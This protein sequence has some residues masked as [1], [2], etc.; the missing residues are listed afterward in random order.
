MTSLIS[1]EFLVAILF[2]ANGVLGILLFLF[3]KRVNRLALIPHP[4]RGESSAAPGENFPDKEAIHD[5]AREI[6][7]MLE[8]LVKESRKA[9]LSFDDQI[10][11]KRRISKD[12]NDALD[13][14]IINI[15]LLLSRAEALQ[16]KLETRQNAIHQAVP[17]FK[18]P[19]S[20]GR[21]GNVMDQQ[22]QILAL[23]YQNTDVDTIAEKLSIPKGEVQLVIDLKEKFIAMEQGQ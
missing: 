11:E 20:P 19:S 14:R 6:M 22:N 21:P 9:A 12:L 5:S 8:P 4:D 17:A 13:S 15:N 10:R 3:V 2:I 7:D 23:Y 1:L 16:G 18:E